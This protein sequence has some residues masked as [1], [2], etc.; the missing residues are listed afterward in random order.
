M[1]KSR[2]RILVLLA[3]VLLAVAG[4]LVEA[5]RF[6]HEPPVDK[7]R[8][9]DQTTKEQSPAAA[10]SRQSLAPASIGPVDRNVIAGGGGTSTGGNFRTDGTVG[11]VSA[12]NTQ[13]G[14]SFTLNGG[15]WNTL[16]TT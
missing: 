16:A 13:S 12:S 3:G 2:P 7:S 14:G 9:L 10:Q 11:E 5:R 8:A 4:A 6:T 15:F 1:R